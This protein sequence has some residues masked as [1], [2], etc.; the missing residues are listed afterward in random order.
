[1]PSC[2]KKTGEAV[3]ESLKKLARYFHGRGAIE[4]ALPGEDVIEPRSLWPWQALGADEVKVGEEVTVTV[5]M[6]LSFSDEEIGEAAKGLAEKL[7]SSG[8]KKPTRQGKGKL[9][10]IE[11][12]LDALSAMRL[13]SHA[14][15]REAIRKF[16]EI[17]LGRIGRLGGANIDRRNFNRLAKKGREHFGFL[18]PFGEP[19][20]NAVEF[21]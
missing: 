16:S 15:K 5:R 8:G 17:Q 19:A 20:A 11:S 2:G 14:G 10:S 7:R 21:S 1:M 4:L 12:L 3:Q 9:N 13:A 6:R 18:F